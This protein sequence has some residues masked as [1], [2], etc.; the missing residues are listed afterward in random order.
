MKAG[1][2]LLSFSLISSESLKQKS[3]HLLLHTCFRFATAV[4]FQTSCS[5]GLPVKSMGRVSDI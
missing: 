2:R 5:P 4:S 3:G 1:A